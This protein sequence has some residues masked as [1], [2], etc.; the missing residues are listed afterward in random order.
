M[1]RHK[2]GGEGGS[3]GMWGSVGCARGLDI[4]SKCVGFGDMYVTGIMLQV[5]QRVKS[6][7]PSKEIRRQL[8]QRSTKAGRVGILARIFYCCNGTP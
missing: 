7:T 1:K 4:F 3:K 6:K 8:P 2:K 5:E